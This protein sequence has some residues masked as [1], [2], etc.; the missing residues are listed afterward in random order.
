MRILVV[1]HPPLTAEFG[2]AQTALTLAAA[3]RNRGHDAMA[4][5]PEPLPPGTRWWN[6]WKQQTQAIERFVENHGPFDVIDIP[7]IS[8]SRRLGD[9]GRLVVRSVQPELLYLLFELWNDLVKRPSPRVLAHAVLGFPRAAAILAGWHRAYRILCLGNH[10]LNWMRRRFPR[11]APKLC[12]YISAPPPH[13]RCALLK[14][15]Q[16]RET[17][18][19]GKRVHFL[20]IGRWAEHKGIRRLVGW[21]EERA[22]I[23]PDDTIT[24]AGCGSMAQRHLSP[25]WVGSGRVRLVPYFSRDELPG[26]LASHDAGLFTSTLEGWGLNL[27]EMLESGMPV[28]ATNAGGVLDLK[29]FFPESLRPFPPPARI[30]FPSTPEDLASNGYFARFDWS[31]IAQSYE[32]SVLAS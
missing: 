8:A 6:V 16:L 22:A 9:Y 5:S 26:L 2:S 19:A 13:E 23:A 3:L 15:R 1:S 20:W 10:E 25:E 31:S 30:D 21:I 24:L 7:A 4:W 12:S 18:P 28:F 29:P 32:E 17:G 14:V 27:N 11:L